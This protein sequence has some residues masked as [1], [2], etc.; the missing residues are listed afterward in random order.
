MLTPHAPH[1]GVDAQGLEVSLRCLP[2]DLLVQRQVSNSSLQPIILGLQLLPPLH[3]HYPEAT[4]LL[5]P[6]IEWPAL[7][8]AEGS[9]R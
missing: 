2:Q 7:S 1:K 8:V 6:P 9:A 3:L 5:A 4:V